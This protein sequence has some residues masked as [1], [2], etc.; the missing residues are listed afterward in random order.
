MDKIFDAHLHII[1]PG[2]PLIENQG[3]VPELFT[4]TAYLHRMKHYE[5]R[6]GAIVSG[7]FQGFDQS[8]LINALK[9]LGQGFR[10]VTQLPPDCTDKEILEL[11]KAGVKA[12]RMNIRRGGR[13]LLGQLEAL[14]E[15]VYG[16]AGWH[17][18]LYINAADLPEISS[19]LKKLP[20][21]SIDHL[22]LQKEG[23]PFL[24]QLAEKGMRVKASGFGRGNLN[25][26]ETI[27]AVYQANPKA[28]MFG[29]DLPST[30]APRPFEDNDIDIIK[31]VLPPEAVK[32]VLYRNAE[33]WYFKK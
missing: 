2:Y 28:L 9:T 25:I 10:G 13:D 33:D 19:I 26:A 23:L 24:L 27:T 11:D 15:R 5:L 30:R 8:Y 17:V 32:D 21:V 1:E 18:E 4:C 31:K 14:A 29:T 16:L 6:G 3:F 7:S 22:G 20:A 12:V